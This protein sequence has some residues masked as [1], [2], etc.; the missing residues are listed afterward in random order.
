MMSVPTAFP[1]AV[2]YDASCPLCR[3]EMEAMKARD[4]GNVLQLV[5]C[6]APDFDA[7]TCTA[8]GV[9]PAMMMARIH[10]RDAAGRWL[11][12]VE[13]FA[14]VY[15]AAGLHRMALVYE[16]ALLRPLLDRLYPWIADHRYLLSRLGLARMF[17]VPAASMPAT[18]PIPPPGEH[19]R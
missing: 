6:S 9:T 3:A 7:V 17:R 2:Y 15:R 10:A 5:D 4:T 8:E 11:R 13:V 12:G 19:G 1:L 16:S 18:C 14:V